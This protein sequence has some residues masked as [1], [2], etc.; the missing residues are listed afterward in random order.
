MTVYRNGTASAPFA[1]HG[2]LSAHAS[3]WRRIAAAL[4]VSAL[5]ATSGPT[6]VM[7]QEAADT[8][9]PESA[10][11][12][13]KRRL[14]TGKN[15]MVAAA[16]PHAVRAGAAVLKKGGSAA[17]ALV[18]VQ[19]VLGLTE[20]QSSGLGGG[21]F[22]VYWDARAE[23]LTTLDGRETAPA[24]ATP[25]LFQDEDGNPLKFFDAVVG[26]R[27]VGVPGTPGLLSEAHRR[28]GV[29]AWARLLDPAIA[30]AEKGFAVSPRLAML[31]ERDA[32]RLQSRAA[33]RAY[34]FRDGKPLPVGTILK[35]P[36]Y[37]ETLRQFA[38]QGDK[39][40]YGG[41]IGDEIVAAVRSDETNPGVMQPDDLIAYRVKERK[42]VCAPY[43]GY[44]VCGMGPPSS[45]ALTVGQ[46]LGLI[47]PFDLAAMGPDNAEA[48]RLIGDASRLAFAD[49][50][51]YMA[52][53]DYVPMPVDGLVDAAYLEKR[54]AILKTGKAL[55]QEQVSPGTPAWKHAR[56]SPYRYADDQSIEFPSTSHISI[57]DAQG[58]IVSMTTTIEN[59]FGSRL[60]AGGFL[61]NNELTDFS[62]RSHKDGVPVANR[63]EPGKRP[64]SSM[65]PTVVLKDGAPVIVIGSPGGSRI[66][67]YVAR[68]LIAMIDWNM[69]VQSAISAP[70][71]VNRFGT[72]DIEKGTGAEAL[73]PKLEALGFEIKVRELN[74]GL[75]GIAITADG[76]QGGA[77][78]RREGI[79][80][81]D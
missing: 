41:S 79:V 75:H 12:L 72:F 78:P 30:L 49:R 36:A 69:D 64:R 23:R 48:W 20:P 42:P 1:I 21:A 53:A 15:W 55:T 56:L 80:L 35:N 27:S 47:A 68:T 62:F 50:A 77:D 66:I 39:A 51:R 7:A 34:F 63:V 5:A 81:A 37:G 13:E 58:N 4:L 9:A 46:I 14:V 32:R 59:G 57:V 67:G 40:F 3:M 45:G 11:Q 71:L 24:A 26:G 73:A 76:L 16:N 28:W 8:I 74:S 54:S 31:L 6:A 22:L 25:T 29:L 19:S 10:T 60:M 43:R 61:L 52:D 17:D 70:H 18:A 44:E 38:R 33:T 65:S 2:F